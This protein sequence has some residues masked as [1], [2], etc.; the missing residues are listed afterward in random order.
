[1][2][3]INISDTLSLSL[4]TR[5]F[6]LEDTPVTIYEPVNFTVR[7]GMYLAGM[8]ALIVLNLVIL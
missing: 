2:R 7:D 5:G 8:L 6:E 3:L 1:M 4:E